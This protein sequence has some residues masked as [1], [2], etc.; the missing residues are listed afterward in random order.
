MRGHLVM[1]GTPLRAQTAVQAPVSR[2]LAAT[3][4]GLPLAARVASRS[5][6]S[7][8]TLWR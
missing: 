6:L 7:L 1:H 8:Q 3:A 5:Q 2:Q 4:H